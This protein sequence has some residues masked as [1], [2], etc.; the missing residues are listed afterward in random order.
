MQVEFTAKSKMLIPSS[1]FAEVR[2]AQEVLCAQEAACPNYQMK[3]L[4]YQIINGTLFNSC[5]VSF[6]IKNVVASAMRFNDE[7][8][9]SAKRTL[10]IDGNQSNQA[11]YDLTVRIFNKLNSKINENLIAS[12]EFG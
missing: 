7:R 10:M 1:S 2:N 6:A 9:A 5:L 11:V 3:L 8:L 12:T 4:S